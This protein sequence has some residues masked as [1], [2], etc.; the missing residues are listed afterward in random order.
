M[1]VLTLNAGS[2]SLKF[3]LFASGRAVLRG[4][5]E[6]IT[7]FAEGV[8]QGRGRACAGAAACGGAWA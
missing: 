2:S 6:D 8:C 4:A 1:V 5:F 3:A 7:G